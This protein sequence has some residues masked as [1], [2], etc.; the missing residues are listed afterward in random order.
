MSS[1][2]ALNSTGAPSL[3]SS[4]SLVTR[5]NGPNDMTSLAS[6]VGVIMASSSQPSARAAF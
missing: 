6:V 2:R 1:A 3:V 4:L 5:L